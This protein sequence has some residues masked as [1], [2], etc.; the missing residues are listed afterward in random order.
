MAGGTDG[1]NVPPTVIDEDSEIG[2]RYIAAM[3]LAGRYAYAGREWVVERLRKIVGGAV[4]KYGAQPPQLCLAREA[5]RPGPVGGSQG[6]YAGLPWPTRFRRRLD[7]RQRRD[8]RRRRKPRGEQ[9][10]LFDSPWRR[11]VIRSEG[12]EASLR[13]RG[14]GRVAD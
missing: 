9:F 11:A 14:D 12:G 1:M 4:T 10:A 13:S 5:R 3:E 2:R 7:G 6:R 8:Y